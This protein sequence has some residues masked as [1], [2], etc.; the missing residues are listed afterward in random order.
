MPK[1]TQRLKV[2]FISVPAWKFNSFV[3]TLLITMML[4]GSRNSECLLL[5]LSHVGKKIFNNR[6]FPPDFI[7]EKVLSF[8]VILLLLR[9]GTIRIRRRGKNSF[10]LCFVVLSPYFSSDF[11]FATEIDRFPDHDFHSTN[12]LDF[13]FTEA[14]KFA[15]IRK[16]IKSKCRC[17][18]GKYLLSSLCRASWRV[19][20]VI[21]EILAS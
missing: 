17:I 7:S 1:T 9:R 12:S 18:F 4:F 13:L 16:M 19:L 5:T 15:S 21:M 3:C 10:K 2:P 6:E 14:S 20:R 8:Y 11:F